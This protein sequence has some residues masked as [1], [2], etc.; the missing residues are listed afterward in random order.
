MRYIGSKA[1]VAS[2]IL[3]L[4]G[5]SDPSAT[6]VDA[7]CGTGS[8]AREAAN[9][10]WRLRINDSLFAATCLAEA[11]AAPPRAD[12]FSELGGYAAAIQ[13][14]N[15]QPAGSGFIRANYSPDSGQR[16]SNERRYLTSEN[17]GRVDAIRAEIAGWRQRG[18]LSL[19]EER[20]LIADLLEATSQV[21]NTAGTYG[22][23][24][25]HWSAPALRP[26][27]L[28][29]RSMGT[30]E[31]GLTVHHGDVWDVPFE[32][33]DVAYLDPPYTKR[34]YAAYYHLLETIAVGDEPEIAGLT[35][36]RPWQ[37]RASAFCYKS[38][39]L[40][41]LS[42]LIAATPAAHI[43]LSYSSQGHV[44]LDAL[45]RRLSALGSVQ[46][47]E[48]GG[49]GRYRPNEVASAAGSTVFEYVL[50]VSRVEE[51]SRE[52]EVA[53]GMPA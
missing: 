37:D 45:E 39:A 30:A 13:Y 50:H 10:G 28:A 25:R 5:P 32:T 38:R 53:S 9:R 31:I 34:Q 11:A 6:F 33:S 46:V 16:G 20:L 4:I 52:S 47:H 12:E 21:A 19:R 8:V 41:A 49:I 2:A 36:L 48:L 3:D 42:S 22:C 43:Y 29:A 26:L 27:R 1:R 44:P 7:F 14:L 23:F 35:G 18:L 15:S 24:L 17:A 40:D 51:P